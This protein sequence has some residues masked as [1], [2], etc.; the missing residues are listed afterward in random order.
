[1][2]TIDLALLI[3]VNIN[4]KRYVPLGRHFMNASQRF[5]SVSLNFLDAFLTCH[6]HTRPATPPPPRL[7]F[8]RFPR[9]SLQHVHVPSPLF[10]P[11]EPLAQTPFLP[12]L[13]RVANCTLPAHMH[14]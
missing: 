4:V 10:P 11:L 6:F 14:A 2:L 7:P 3:A 1:M 12:A 5:H 9:L 8:V 13:N